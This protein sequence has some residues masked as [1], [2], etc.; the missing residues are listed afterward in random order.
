MSSVAVA[1][2]RP[3]R[4]PL[5]VSLSIVAAGAGIAALA[6]TAA[7]AMPAAIALAVSGLGAGALQTMGPAMAATAVDTQEKGE[8]IAVIGTVR[9]AAQFPVPLAL[10]G[11]LSVIPLIAAVA[12]SGGLLALPAGAALRR[13]GRATPRTVAG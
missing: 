5:A 8:A 4:A 6:V 7:H 10:A 1:R 12:L 3:G 2:V 13:R 11:M 9:A